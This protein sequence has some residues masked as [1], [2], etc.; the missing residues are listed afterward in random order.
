MCI[1]SKQTIK[2]TN[3]KPALTSL[4]LSLAFGITAARN[5]VCAEHDIDYEISSP[6]AAA[7]NDAPSSMSAGIRVGWY[8][9]KAILEALYHEYQTQEAIALETDLV[10]PEHTE[11]T[12]FKV[13]KLSVLPDVIPSQLRGKP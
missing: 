1:D 13:S 7:V 10:D 12:A 2:M 3:K 11:I 6:Y 4:D 9:I 5:S 8:K